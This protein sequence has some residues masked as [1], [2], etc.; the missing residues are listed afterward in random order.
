[1][2]ISLNSLRQV[3][4]LSLSKKNTLE[5]MGISDEW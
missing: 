1:M 3:N 4:Y 2:S 5:L